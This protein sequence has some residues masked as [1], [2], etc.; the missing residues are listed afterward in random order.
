MKKRGPENL[1]YGIGEWFGQV[2]DKISLQ[3]I[4]KYSESAKLSK[5]DQPCP[6]RKRGTFVPNCN[7]RGGVCSVRLYQKTGDA[8]SKPHD[9]RLVTLCPQRFYQE[10][11]IFKE[12]SRLILN[13][14]SPV[15]VRE[16][17]FLR[18]EK[19]EDVGRIDSV[20]VIRDSYPLAWCAVE[21]QAV[22]FSGLNMGVEFERLSKLDNATIPFP[23]AIR[24]PDF[25]SSGPKRLM[26]QLQIKVP[27]LRRWGKKIAVVVDL[28][29][30]SSMGKMESTRDLSNADIA[31]VIVDYQMK[32]KHGDLF[33]SS[34]CYTTLEMAITGLTAGLPV[35]LSEFEEDI[36]RR[37][38]TGVSVS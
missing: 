28:A 14:S 24:R 6:F 37:I 12:I 30:F 15:L 10:D 34:I 4:R 21:I 3:E 19:A 38:P 35:T 8:C 32:E 16:V 23:V 7:K 22:Y 5:P 26:P 18:G 11:L 20:L 17:G 29:F 33:V 9:A 36:I 1:R 25:R 2:L 13:N 27:T 31:W